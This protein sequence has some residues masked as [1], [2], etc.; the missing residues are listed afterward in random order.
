MPDSRG[1]H[2]FPIEIAAAS[3]LLMEAGIVIMGIVIITWE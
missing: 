3:E 1:V 2:G